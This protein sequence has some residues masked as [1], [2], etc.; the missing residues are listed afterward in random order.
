M[1]TTLELPDD[2]FRRAKA[3]AA[4]QGRSLKEFIAAG[5]R[6]ELGEGSDG[7]SERE[8][9]SLH[10]RMKDVCGIG[11]HVE[12]PEDFLTNPKYMDGFGE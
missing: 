10:D 12:L 8:K 9:L 4:L 11:P 5:L 2:L 3:A 6:K 7:N 1:K